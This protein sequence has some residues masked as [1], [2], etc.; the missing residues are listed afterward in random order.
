MNNIFKDIVNVTDWGNERG[1]DPQ[2]VLS[3][4]KRSQI[5]FYKYGNL[6][7]AKREDLDNALNEDF[8][9]QTSQKDR[10]RF[11]ATKAA[12]LRSAAFKF[13]E[14]HINEKFEDDKSLND[15]K[16][17]WIDEAIKDFKKK[18]EM[19]KEDAAMVSKDLLIF[20]ILFPELKSFEN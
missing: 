14:D 1:L 19:Q 2:S 3:L 4:I 9:K 10:K 12:V 7:K 20:D 8:S 5:T 18:K 15:F 11:K 17:K 6:V 16:K 13:W